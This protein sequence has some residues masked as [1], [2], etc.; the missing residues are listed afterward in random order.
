MRS[1]TQEWLLAHRDYP[2]DDWCLIWPFYRNSIVGRGQ[3]EY[4]GNSG[5]AHRFMCELVYGPAPDDKPLVAHSCGNGDL[6]CVNPRHLSWSTH[7]EN[8][9]QRY[10][11]GRGNPNAN[12]NKSRFTEAQIAEIRAKHGEFTTIKLA[13]MYGCSIG[14]IQ[15]YLKYRERRGHTGGKIEH[16]TP[17]QEAQLQ[18][19]FAARQTPATMTRL[20]GKTKGAIDAKLRRM[21]LKSVTDPGQSFQRASKF[22]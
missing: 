20:I 12:G 15:Y 22:Q 13:E 3:M 10:A 17:E 2:H 6:G 7:S 18:D 1:K 4:E 14:A 5:Y 9:R 8:Q 11:D 16:W 21:G 19:C